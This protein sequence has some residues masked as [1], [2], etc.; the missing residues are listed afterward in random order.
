V[1]M[2]GYGPVVSSALLANAL[3]RL[4]HDSGQQQKQVA[5]ALEWSV[6]KLI[7]AESCRTQI[8]RTD[9]KALLRYYGVSDQERADELM[10]WAR[11]ARTAGWWRR[12]RIRDQAFERY[13]G[14]ETGCASVRMVQGLLVPGILQTEEYARLITRT[15]ATSEEIDSVILL[16]L[17]RQRLLFARAPR[18]HHILD[19]AVLRRRVGNA[20]PGQLQHL[21]ELARQPEITIQVVP[22]ATGPHFGMR[23]PFVLLGFDVPLA[24]MLF[25]E[26]GRRSD[27]I[28]SEQEVFPGQG[29]PG[30]HDAAEEIARYEDGF[31][32]L[33]RIALE[34][35]ESMSLIGQIASQAH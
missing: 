12:F 29:I 19:E 17:E 8:S 13:V 22:F 24:N 32:A 15:Y 11:E 3:K 26:S 14:Y 16:R 27:V 5:D 7:R 35:A 20:M 18:Q 1:T 21:I 9:L 33:S 4:R 34:P 23:G 10:T 2:S 28:V 31:A 6:S 25:L 30:I